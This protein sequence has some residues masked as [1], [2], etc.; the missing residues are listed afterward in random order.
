MAKPRN[1]RRTLLAAL[2]ITRNRLT[3]IRD[4][5]TVTGKV[6]GAPDIP[7]GRS[8]RPRRD[9]EYPEGSAAE[10]RLVVSQID[11]AISELVKI[12]DF[13]EAQGRRATRD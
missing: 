13:A 11:I 5:W 3:W 9:D 2:Q 10:W 1:P 4:R 7:K 12:R 8:W 6:Y